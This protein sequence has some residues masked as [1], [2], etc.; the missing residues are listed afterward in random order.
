MAKK[1]VLTNTFSL[2]EADAI[3]I[4]SYVML[5]TTILL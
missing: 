2:T 1:L 5:N 3:V 4:V